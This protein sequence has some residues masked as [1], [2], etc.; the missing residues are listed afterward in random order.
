MNEKVLQL[1]TAIMD[2]FREEEK[3]ELSFFPKLELDDDLTGDVT[4]LL[5]AMKTFVEN[6]VSFDGD[7]IDFT[8]LLNKLAVQFVVEQEG[9]R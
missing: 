2:A 1:L 9:K 5:L 3:R 6:I 4:A 8:H 7:L